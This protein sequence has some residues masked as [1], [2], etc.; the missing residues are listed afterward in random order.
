MI[1]TQTPYRISFFGGG[2]DYREWYEKNGG[3]F[4]SMSIDKYCHIFVRHLPPFFPYKSRV[5]W[6]KIE[7]VMSNS[8]ITHPVVAAALTDAKIEQVELHHIG[9]LPARSGLGSS[10][11][12]VV[13]LIHGLS[14]L[15]GEVISR[16]ELAKAA[17]DLERNT[18]GELGG[19]QD[20]IAVTF[21]GMNVVNIQKNGEFMLE[22]VELNGHK[23]EQFE[24]SLMLVFTGLF[25]TSTEVLEGYP[26]NSAQYNRSLENI[27]KITEQA[28]S[29][30]T[31]TTLAQDFGVLMNETWHLKKQ[32]SQNIS[33]TQID[34][35]YSEAMS[36][37]AY[38]G[39]LLGAGA[40]GFMVFSV[41]V[42]KKKAVENRLRKLIHVPVKLDK[43]G[44]T[45]R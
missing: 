33:N 41:P 21:G 45:V 3:S 5:V 19:I 15:K 32:L 12:F 35:I 10:S 42:E 30:L 27:A 17:I 7:Q 1:L 16:E 24:S 23:L 31:S 36:A 25:R 28:K 18:L 8:D 13:G 9:D 29:V 43:Q 34:E 37:G 11:S 22:P 4:I 26:K 14:K 2:T 44:A 39:K 6:S 40:G 20:Q 38:G